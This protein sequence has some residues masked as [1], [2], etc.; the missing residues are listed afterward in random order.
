MKKVKNNNVCMSGCQLYLD[1]D[2][3]K[4]TYD[5][6]PS[7]TVLA[8]VN[9]TLEKIEQLN[10]TA[11][12]ENISTATSEN[13][14][15]AT[16]ENNSTATDLNSTTTDANSPVTNLN[17]TDSVTIT[18]TNSTLKSINETLSTSLLSSLGN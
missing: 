18:D 3:S 12:S 4:I 11:T 6:P 9:S 14:S 7:P 2:C 17:S 16:T 1:V 15:T 13:N 10:S 5:T 8:A